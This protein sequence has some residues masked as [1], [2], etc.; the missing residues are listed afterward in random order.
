[1]NS[2]GVR[3]QMAVAMAPGLTGVNV[4]EAKNDGNVAHNNNILNQMANNTGISQF[5]SSWFF[6]T[7]AN[8]Q[9]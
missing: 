4:Y 8:T 1:M 6:G 5:S 9:P 3:I 7:D 2:G